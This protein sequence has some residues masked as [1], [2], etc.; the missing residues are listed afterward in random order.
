MEVEAPQT[1]LQEVAIKKTLVLTLQLL[2]GK[3]EGLLAA[4]QRLDIGEDGR[5]PLKVDIDLYVVATMR[6]SFELL[7]KIV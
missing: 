2:L 6:H 5:G 7:H 3:R 4:A 1:S